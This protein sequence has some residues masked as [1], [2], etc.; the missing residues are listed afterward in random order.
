MKNIFKYDINKTG[1][2]IQKVQMPINAEILAIRNQHE[3]AVIWAEVNATNLL[4]DRVFAVLTTGATKPDNPM[5][6][7]TTLQFSDGNY[8]IHI[9]ELI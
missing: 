2:I 7:K 6:Y 8:V 3:E 9:Y 4:E 1:R 5:E